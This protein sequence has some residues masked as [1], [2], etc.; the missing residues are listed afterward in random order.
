MGSWV[1]YVHRD[2]ETSALTTRPP[3]LSKPFNR[4]ST[5]FL[6][7]LTKKSRTDSVLNILF[8]YVILLFINKAMN[9]IT[10]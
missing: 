6:P 2:P 4:Q 7:S 8:I 1:Q 10:N 5:L 9:L 3:G